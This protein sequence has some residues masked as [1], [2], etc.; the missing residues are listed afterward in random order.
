MYCKIKKA[1]DAC[2][3]K[4]TYRYY[5]PFFHV[6]VLENIYTGNMIKRGLRC[7]HG[8]NWEKILQSSD[9]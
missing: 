5:F 9:H 4:I 1:I 3:W 7:F 2:A 8:F 6:I